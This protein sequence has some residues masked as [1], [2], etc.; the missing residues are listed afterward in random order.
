MVEIIELTEK[1]SSIIYYYI[2]RLKSGRVYSDRD[3]R[4]SVCYALR[5]PSLI[6]KSSYIKR[7]V[8]ETA[9]PLYGNIAK[10]KLFLNAI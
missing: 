8:C 2:L 5:Y 3:V 7:C 1:I 9:M 6:R 10:I 4:P